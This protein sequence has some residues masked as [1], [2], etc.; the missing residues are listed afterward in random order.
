MSD[1]TPTQDPEPNPI[2]ELRARTELLERQLAEV[3]RRTE[4]DRKSVV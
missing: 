1:D 3:Q 4:A 2:D